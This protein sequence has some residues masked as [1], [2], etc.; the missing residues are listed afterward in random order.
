MNPASLEFLHTTFVLLEGERRELRLELN[1]T[2]PDSD[3]HRLRAIRS[4]QLFHNVLDVN[5]DGF[6]G[7]EELRGDIAISIA[8][9]EMTQNLDLTG[10]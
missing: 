4:T 6:L 5:L 7:N 9:R 2:P 3:G 8:A 1:D 10:G